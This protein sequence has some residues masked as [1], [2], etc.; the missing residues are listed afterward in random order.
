MAL[1][2]G[3][4]TQASVPLVGRMNFTLTFV[5][6]PVRTTDSEV[7]LSTRQ[8]LLIWHSQD[9][10]LFNP[11]QTPSCWSTFRPESSWRMAL[12]ALDLLED[13]EAPLVGQLECSVLSSLGPSSA[14]H[15]IHGSPRTWFCIFLS[16][17]ESRA[18]PTPAT[19]CPPDE[20][21]PSLSPQPLPWW[22][23]TP[24]CPLLCST[25]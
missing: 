15:K 13:L 7:Y 23:E 22:P 8:R 11:L 18:S 24:L 12:L 20:Y 1:G 3:P 19:L 10:A 21:L 6:L 17:H 2:M 25:P 5:H 4:G 9:F 14:T 16:L